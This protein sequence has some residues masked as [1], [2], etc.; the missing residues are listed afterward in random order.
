M[1][2]HRDTPPHHALSLVREP[3]SSA[4]AALYKHISLSFLFVAITNRLSDDHGEIYIISS[5]CPH[6]G[7]QLLQW[8][9]GIR[10]NEISGLCV[11]FENGK[12]CF[13]ISGIIL[14]SLKFSFHLEVKIFGI[15]R[16]HEE[17]F[18]RFPMNEDML[19]RELRN[20]CIAIWKSPADE[21]GT[22]DRHDNLLGNEERRLSE[23]G[24]CRFR[25][26]DA[27]HK[28][29]E[30]LHGFGKI[31]GCCIQCG[32]DDCKRKRARACNT[33]RYERRS[34]VNDVMGAVCFLVSSSSCCRFRFLRKS[35][36]DPSGRSVTPRQS[37]DIF[38]TKFK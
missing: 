34:N 1:R 33:L 23:E 26:S 14:N 7:C 11:G 20:T 36:G 3:D 18:V 21:I 15:R 19:W 13:A 27:R 5:R 38:T 24:G 10:P 16:F 2:P 37:Q 22:S 35:F 29:Q 6:F 17:S 12:K 30:Y 28:S 9:W 8:S 32:D 25:R 31:H 4:A